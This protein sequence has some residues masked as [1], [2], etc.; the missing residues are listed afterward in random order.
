MKNV[1]LLIITA[2]I[3]SACK[4][5]SYQWE[6]DTVQQAYN[7]EAGFALIIESP[8]SDQFETVV[9]PFIQAMLMEWR[10]VYPLPQNPVVL[11]QDL[12]EPDLYD[13]LFRLGGAYF[14]NA[15]NQALVMALLQDCWI[16]LGKHPRYKA[17]LWQKILA[18]QRHLLVRIPDFEKLFARYQLDTVS[19]L[20]VYAY[21]NLYLLDE[22]YFVSVQE[23][24]SRPYRYFHDSFYSSI[25]S[26][27]V[28]LPEMYGFYQYLYKQYGTRRLMKALRTSYSPDAWM[29]IF[30]EG[31]NETE[32]GFRR[33]IENTT[34]RIFTAQP[35][36]KSELDS[37]LKLYN[38]TT[39]ATLFKE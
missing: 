23:L 3:F 22:I 9:W 19:L 30:G 11:R 24:M 37:L 13:L 6:Y 16:R 10:A 33:S 17:M 26:Q 28:I 39:K 18:R 35:A 8:S 38:T 7:C 31:V 5:P 4:R 20:E 29:K 21:I 27:V 1:L 12:T 15:P 34:F 36:L 25:F 14:Q 2:G 32:D